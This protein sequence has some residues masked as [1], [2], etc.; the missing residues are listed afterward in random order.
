MQYTQTTRPRACACIFH[1]TL[2]LMLYLLHAIY[3]MR[4]SHSKLDIII[5]IMVCFYRWVLQSWV[6]SRWWDDLYWME[7]Y[8]LNRCWVVCTVTPLVRLWKCMSLMLS[9]ITTRYP[10]PHSIPHSIPHY[11]PPLYTP[12]LY[13]SIPPLYTPTRYIPTLYTPISIPPTPYPHTLFYTAPLSIS[14]IKKCSP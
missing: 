2:G 4:T 7:R 1:K 5:I 9:I 10:S 14:E 11:T 8:Q 6:T 12:T 3:N 13:P